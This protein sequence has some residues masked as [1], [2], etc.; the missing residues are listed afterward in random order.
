MWHNAWRTVRGVPLGA[1]PGQGAHRIMSSRN[2]LRVLHQCV[3]RFSIRGRCNNRETPKRV[4]PG[5]RC[6]NLQQ[7]QQ[8]AM[9]SDHKP[10]ISLGAACQLQQTRVCCT[11]CTHLQQCNKLATNSVC[12]TFH[13]IGRLRA[14]LTRFYCEL[15]AMP[16]VE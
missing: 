1:M 5:R 15:I 3:F 2:S 9:C 11:C 7:V 6:T 13:I 8:R 14:R 10:L 4:F 12:C 16:G